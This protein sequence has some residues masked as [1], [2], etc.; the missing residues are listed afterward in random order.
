MRL[1]ALETPPEHSHI[2]RGELHDSLS[3]RIFRALAVAK[4]RGRRLTAVAPAKMKGT[5]KIRSSGIW[6]R[7]ER[8]L[9]PTKCRKCTCST[10]AWFQCHLNTMTACAV[11]HHIETPI[12]PLGLTPHAGWL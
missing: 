10:R 4:R 5:W 3:S 8:A 1:D 12:G 9:P 6:P 7:K 2:M 11:G